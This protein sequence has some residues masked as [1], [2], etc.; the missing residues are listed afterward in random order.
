[1]YELLAA[2]IVLKVVAILTATEV[3]S[4]AWGG[5]RLKLLYLKKV[6]YCNNKT[7]YVTSIELTITS[8]DEVAV[9]V[10][11]LL[12]STINLLESTTFKL[13]PIGIETPTTMFALVEPEYIVTSAVAALIVELLQ[14][15]NPITVDW[16]PAV[17][18][19]YTIV[20]PVMPGVKKF[21][22]AIV[23]WFI[24][25]INAL[26]NEINARSV[27]AMETP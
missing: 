1:M 22:Y 21:L 17:V 26:V 4:T 5:I 15:I 10:T 24:Y 14:I 2:I 8:T 20:L 7:D 25:A 9:T 19:L 13:V 11:M 23:I 18:G 6:F 27:G 16:I 3:W 12:A